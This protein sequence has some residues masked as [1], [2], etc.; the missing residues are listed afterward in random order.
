MDF[1]VLP[2]IGRTGVNNGNAVRRLSNMTVTGYRE[3]DPAATFMA[4]QLATLATVDS[5][6][7]VQLVD[8][9]GDTVVGVFF[10]DNTTTFYRPSYA[11]E[12]TF[13]E[14]A[15]TPNVIYVNPYVKASSY[16]VNSVASTASGTTYVDTTAY[17]IDVTSGAITN[18]LSGAI[19]ATGTVY[20]TY[21]YKDINLSGLNQVLGSGKAALLEEV[22]E[23]ATLRYDTT[24]TTAYAL[25]GIIYSAAN[26]Y[27][28]ATSGGK[29]LG[30]ITK[31][32]TAD[33]PELWVKLA[34][35][36]A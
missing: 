5:V 25:N 19:A 15:A 12:H 9:T 23:I 6:P 30:Y 31:V 2:P 3:V 32:P 7:K 27:M 8:G 4:G 1:S 35:T 17:S 20:V 26:G 21:L 33:D 36:A 29:T 14:N 10:T 13:G 16:N 24:S 11:E 34:L 18:L 22:G 28:T